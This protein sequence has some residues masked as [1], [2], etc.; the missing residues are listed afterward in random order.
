MAINKNKMLGSYEAYEEIFSGAGVV[1]QIVPRGEGD[2]AV[3]TIESVEFSVKEFI[4]SRDAV[5]MFPRVVQKTLIEAAEPVYTVTPLLN[6]VR[7]NTG[8][9][10]VD[11]MAIGAMQAFEVPEG[12]EYPTED[13]AWSTGSKTAKV[14]KKGLRI[15]ITDEMLEDSQ[16]DLIA[17]YMR[18]AGRAMAR[19]K[20]QLAVARFLAAAGENVLI[21]NATATWANGLYS[22]GRGADGALNGT[23]DSQDLLKVVGA[24]SANGVNA[25]DILIH[26]MAFAMW[27]ND[28]IIKSAWYT[29]GLGIGAAQLKLADGKISQAAGYQSFLQRTAPM[30]LNIITSPYIPYDAATGRTDVVLIDRNDVGAITVREDMS[31]EQFDDP[32]R[33]IISMKVKERYDVTIFPSTGYNVVSLKNLHVA[34]NYG[35]DVAFTG[36]LDDAVTDANEDTTLAGI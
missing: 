20:E 32:T 7:I 18:A 3:S 19:Y 6:Q 8:V 21:D 9:R 31:S 33:D 23:L 29:Q 22:T 5:W 12:M 17:M 35:S 27:A 11:Y 34:R 14:T 13:L 24:M 36:T 2:D 25:T 10:T 4:G 30:G 15:P 1:E 26:P 16:F 28:P